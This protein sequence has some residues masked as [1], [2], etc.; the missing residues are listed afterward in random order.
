MENIHALHTL[1]VIMLS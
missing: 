1:I